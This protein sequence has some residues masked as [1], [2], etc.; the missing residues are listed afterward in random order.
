MLT[1]IGYRG[2]PIR[3]LPFDEPLRWCPTTAAG[4]STRRRCSRCAAATWRAGSSAARP[5]SSVPTSRA[6]RRPCTTWSPTTTTGCWPT[7]SHKPAALDRLVRGR[8]P[9]V[10]DAAGWKAI[11]DAE[12]ARGGGRRPRDKFT[13][14]ADM[15]AAAAAAPRRQCASG[16]WRAC[17]AR[18]PRTLLPARALSPK[19]RPIAAPRGGMQGGMKAAAFVGRVG[20]LA[21]A[22]GVGAAVFTGSDP[23]SRGRHARLVDPRNRL[24]ASAS[25]SESVDRSARRC[26][27]VGFDAS[28]QATGRY[29]G[30]GAD[31][32]GRKPRRRRSTGSTTSRPSR[33]SSSAPSG[34]AHEFDAEPSDVA[35]EEPQTPRPSLTADPGKSLPSGGRPRHEIAHHQTDAVEVKVDAV[36][37]ARRSERRR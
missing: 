26:R 1:S 28:G 29:S 14:V 3:G 37:Q 21:V 6:R 31:D 5:G 32:R 34:A 33:T 15:L 23:G 10:I 18:G 35:D 30:N 11:D 19:A 2:K 17:V 9:D 20:G 4:W 13:D 36:E 16:C 27:C 7:R 8:Q 22:L 24:P 12:V 25:S